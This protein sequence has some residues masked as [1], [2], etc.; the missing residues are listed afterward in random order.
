MKLL[1]GTAWLRRGVRPL[2]Q[3]RRSEDRAPSRRHA[4]GGF[5]RGGG[6]LACCRTVRTRCAPEDRGECCPA[7]DERAVGD[8]A[9]RAVG[10]WKT[11]VPNK[12]A[13]A[14]NSRAEAGHSAISAVSHQSTAKRPTQGGRTQS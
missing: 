6:C 1:R 11:V 4:A 7:G 9:A 5:P 10:G 8:R 14:L 13:G 2:R 12:R 3:R